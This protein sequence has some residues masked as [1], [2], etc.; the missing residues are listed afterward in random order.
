MYCFSYIIEFFRKLYMNLCLKYKKKEK[1]DKPKEDTVPYVINIDDLIS[2][3][4]DEVKEEEE[5]KAVNAKP[6]ITEVEYTG[7]PKCIHK[8]K[9]QENI[10]GKTTEDSDWHKV[11]DINSP[12]SP[13]V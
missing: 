8:V 10:S 2:S 1:V 7:E 6:S 4:R 3:I 11:N 13:P 9:S 5:K 12:V